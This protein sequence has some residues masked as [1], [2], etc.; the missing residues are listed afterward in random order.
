MKVQHTPG[1]WELLGAMNNVYSE[2]GIKNASG[3]TAYEN[4]RWHIAQ[5]GTVTRCKETAQF[6]EIPEKELMA[7]ARLIAAAPELLE[8][9]EALEVLTSCALSGDE[10]RLL[11]VGLGGSKVEDKLFTRCD[12]ITAA[13]EAARAAIAKAKGETE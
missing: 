6:E 7:N 8:A 5:I 2:R 11:I 10:S 3:M 13:F 12:D 4:D 9:L 1:P